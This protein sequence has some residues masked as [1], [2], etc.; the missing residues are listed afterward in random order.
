MIKRLGNRYQFE[1][2][3]AVEFLGEAGRS[4]TLQSFA[5]DA[6]INVIMA[7]YAK[8]GFLV[9]P[10]LAVSRKP[11]FGDFT[12]AGDFLDVQNKILAA[13]NWFGKLPSKVRQEFQNSPVVLLDFIDKSKTDEVK[14]KRLVELGMLDPKPGSETAAVSGT[15]PAVPAA[16]PAPAGNPGS[17]AMSPVTG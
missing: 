5:K 12:K 9:D 10:S 4:R 11:M 3:P 14:R 1:R 7:K 16:S 13:N 8:T 15:A 6:D 17:A 2:V